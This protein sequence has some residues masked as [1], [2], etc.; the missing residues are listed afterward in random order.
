MKD[1]R[2]FRPDGKE[3]SDDDWNVFTRC[4]GLGLAGDAITDVD[5]EGRPVVDDT[6]L[7]LINAHGEPP[8]A[9]VLL[10][11]QRYV[12]WDPSLDTREPDDQPRL[13]PFRGG[14]TSELEAHSLA[15]FGPGRANRSARAGRHVQAAD[16]VE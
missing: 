11:H 10:A 4:F 13:R 8:I 7:L 2:W 14:Q 6:L 3:M 1:L 9:F 5:A 12:C 16:V 15:L